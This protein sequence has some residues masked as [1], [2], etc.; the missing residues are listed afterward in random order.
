MDQGQQLLTDTS[1]DKVKNVISKRVVELLKTNEVSYSEIKKLSIFI[2]EELPTVKDNQEL[3]MFFDYLLKEYPFI[4][5][6]VNILKNEMNVVKEKAVIGKLEQ[7]IKNY[8]V[9]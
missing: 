5:N 8:N 6:E 2:A 1:R 4:K 7:Y 9:K 3:I